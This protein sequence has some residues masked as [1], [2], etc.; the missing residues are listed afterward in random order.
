[1]RAVLQD[2]YAPATTNKLLVA[3]RRVLREARRLG[4]IGQEDYATAVDLKAVV[5]EKP[6]AAAGRALT[7]GELLALL[8][9]CAADPS[10]A[11]VRDGALI[12]V[13]YACGLRRAELVGLDLVSFEASTSTLIVHGKR[14]KTRAI[15]LDGS[16]LD[17]LTDWL[18]LRGLAAGPLFVRILKGGK[19]TAQRLT[20]QAVYTIQHARATAA[21]VPPFSPHDLRRTYAG[22]LLDAGVDLAT[23]QQLMGHSDANTTARYDR[24]GER[25]KR[26]AARMLHVPYRRRA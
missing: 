25:A 4:Q 16:A 11:G 21:G 17:A 18:T 3:L 15:P 19:L 7:P 5:G 12:A 22:D 1:M 10:P 8:S 14:N 24:R 6:T 13:A 26:Q 9:H 20:P 23:V 2:R